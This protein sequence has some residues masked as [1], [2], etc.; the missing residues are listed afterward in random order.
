MHERACDRFAVGTILLGLDERLERV[1]FGLF[2]LLRAHDDGVEGTFL[3]AD[4]DHAVGRAAVVVN[5]ITLAK[6]F[7]VRADLHAHFALDDDVHFL[8]L[9]GG[10]LDCNLLLRLVIRHGD[11][12]GLCRFALKERGKI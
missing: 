10:K 8:P 4:G 2:L 6:F 1:L 9:M 12:K 11:K 5:G 3:A 7:D